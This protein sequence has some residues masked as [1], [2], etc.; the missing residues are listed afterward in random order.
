MKRYL[1]WLMCVTVAF[2]C[3]VGSGS[4]VCASEIA[5]VTLSGSGEVA[6]IS[7]EEAKV[8]KT[9]QLNAPIPLR[10]A[11]TPDGKT[12]IVTCDTGYICF[13]DVAKMELV[14][15][16]NLLSG[17]EQHGT[18]LQP[19][20][21]EDV[22]A[23]PDGKTALVTEG[24]ELGQLFF[25][26]IETVEL[27]DEPL[28]IGD[29]G[30]TVIVRSSGSEAYV[31]DNGDVHIVNLL[32]RTFV[33]FPQPAG[34]DEISDFALTPDESR[35]IF[36]D[37]DN[38][39]YLLDTNTWSILDKRQVN[40]DRFTEP[41]QVAVSPGGTVA[42][43]TND[44]DQSITFVTVGPSS[45]NIG[46]TIEVGG[47]ANGVAFTQDGQTAVVA[48]TNTSL[49]KIIDVANRQVK[50][51]VQEKLGLAPVGV[52]I[53]NM[54]NDLPTVNAGPDQIVFDEV[55]L[56]GSVSYDPD[57]T[58]VS[59]QWELQ[60]R[61]NSGCN[62]TAEG[63]GPTVSDLA[64]GFYDV[65]LIVTDNDGAVDTDEMFFTAIGCKGDFDGDHDV[66]G[67]DLAK[68]AVNF[69]RTDCPSSP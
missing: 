60:H 1:Y 17:P 30:D 8:L 49:V 57:G 25:V 44:T 16:L 7:I 55:T 35:A 13:V 41:N 11:V 19:N 20:H 61:E 6:F 33:T 69:G 64:P 40:E 4:G 22:D 52:A 10:V 48:L 37:V 59:Y 62:R 47:C 31:L 2:V 15:I 27:S 67:S 24:N 14:K 56:D 39:I 42:I 65:T 66:D 51:T 54:E 9:I 34:T 3:L 38:W 68:F 53:V 58:I 21:F 5:I 45:L 36:I 29:G 18:T 43:V 23:T 63:V 46:E 26:D 12:A 28:M 50:A 32:E